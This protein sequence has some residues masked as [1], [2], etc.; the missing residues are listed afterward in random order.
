MQ[1]LRR[2]LPVLILL[3]LAAAAYRGGL[4]DALSWPALG[5]RLVGWRSVV[6]SH[7]VAAALLYVGVYAAIVGVSLPTGGVL[8]VLGGALFGAPTGGALAVL[9]AG[10]GA[11]LLF[12]AARSAL[13]HWLAIGARPLVERLRPALERDGFA[14]LLAL[15]LIPVVPFW[16]ANL[17]PA[18]LGMRLLPYAAATVL[19][20]VPA[21]F[22]LAGVGA[23]AE[24]VLA[25]GQAPDLAVLVSWP[26][27]LPLL[28][29]AALSLA[30]AVWRRWRA[31]HA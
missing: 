31:H 14:A 21:T 8:T 29:L 19:G 5:A 4:G 27:L 15:R 25:Q 23:G 17:A 28:G 18:S 13:G 2:L 26:V 20:I 10:L 24:G 12:L 11:V 6:L 7:P 16:L 1:T 3:A 9:A 30:P 22:V